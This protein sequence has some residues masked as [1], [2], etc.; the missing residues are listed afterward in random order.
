MIERAVGVTQYLDR[1]GWDRKGDGMGESGFTRDR[2]TGS[3]LVI[4]TAATATTARPATQGVLAQSA[5]MLQ[6]GQDWGGWGV[7]KGRG[8]G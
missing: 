1:Q 6:V 3:C 5:Y 7:A 4:W 8:G 2:I